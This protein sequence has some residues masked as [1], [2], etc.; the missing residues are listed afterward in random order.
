MRS[1][2][3]LLDMLVRFWS[4]NQQFLEVGGN[5]LMIEVEDIYFIIG[6]SRFGEELSL[7]CI[8]VGSDLS[9]NDYIID[10]FRPRLRKYTNK[11][12]I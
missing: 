2:P 6:L 10:Y 9:I 8:L 5:Q 4:L 1:Q 12:P 3:Q 7:S 11:I